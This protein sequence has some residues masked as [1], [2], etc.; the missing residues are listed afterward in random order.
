MPLGALN[1]SIDLT[2]TTTVKVTG[3]GTATDDVQLL[4]LAILAFR[5]P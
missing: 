2:T 1:T 3:E 4:A 5:T